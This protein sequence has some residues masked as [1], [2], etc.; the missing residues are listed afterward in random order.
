MF[1]VLK[2]SQINNKM[3]FIT[4]IAFARVKF[5]HYLGH[6]FSARVHRLLLR[7]VLQLQQFSSPA[8]LNGACVLPVATNLMKAN[9]VDV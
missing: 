2:P 8:S 7:T 4:F 5:C 1:S 3:V 6:Y 9:A